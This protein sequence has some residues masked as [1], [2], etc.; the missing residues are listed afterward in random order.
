MGELGNL[1]AFLESQGLKKSGGALRKF[2][3]GGVVTGKTKNKDTVKAL[4][5]PGEL[6]IPVKHST[7]VKKFLKSEKI[8]LPGMK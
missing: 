7:K 1:V 5:T 8:R 4:L 2:S 6:V 3:K